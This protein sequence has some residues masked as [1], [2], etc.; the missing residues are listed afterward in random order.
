MRYPQLTLML[1]ILAGC[2]TH[3]PP[4]AAFH[5]DRTV[6]SWSWPE[7]ENNTP[8]L[9]YEL[10]KKKF[11]GSLW[12]KSKED[13]RLLRDRF[14]TA[15]RT[16]LGSREDAKAIRKAVQDHMQSLLPKWSK[17]WTEIRWLSH[18]I[19]IVDSSWY[20]TPTASA[21]Y[22]LVLQRQEGVWVVLHTYQMYIS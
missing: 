5:E 6:A 12:P 16:S 10:S 19:V 20:Q 14:S 3:E 8:A 13:S 22:L 21:G 1:C 17:Q 18:D 2:A 4:A 9:Y 11:K 7:H 15:S